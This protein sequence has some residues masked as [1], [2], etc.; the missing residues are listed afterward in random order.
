MLRRRDHVVEDV[1]LLR[2]VAGEVPRLA[3]LAAAAKVDEA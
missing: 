2:E 1:L 3:E